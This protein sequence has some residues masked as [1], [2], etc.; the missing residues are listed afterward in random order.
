MPGLGT[1][2]FF[3]TAIAV[4][5]T[6]F[7]AAAGLLKRRWRLLIPFAPLVLL[8]LPMLAAPLYAS[9]RYLYGIA[10]AAPVCLGVALAARRNEGNAP[11]DTFDHTAAPR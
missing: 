11:T 2:F 3:S 1:S 10:C 5:V 7:A 9:Y 8:Y 4:W 6:V